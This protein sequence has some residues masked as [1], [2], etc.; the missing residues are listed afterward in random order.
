MHLWLTG[1]LP[2]GMQEVTITWDASEHGI[3]FAIR[4]EPHWILHCVGREFD[5]AS[6]CGNFPGSL[7]G[8]SSSQ[9]KG[10][11]YGGSTWRVNRRTVPY[12][13]LLTTVRQHY[14][15]CR[16][17]HPNLIFRRRPSSSIAA[18]SRPGSSQCAFM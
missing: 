9:G 5:T 7:R 17:A 6:F 10:R 14:G 8:S 4:E 16:R 15:P 3:V 2:E 13:F 11:G 1:R 18:A 12:R